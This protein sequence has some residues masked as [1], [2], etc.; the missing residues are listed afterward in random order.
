MHPSRL[1]GDLLLKWPRAAASW[2]EAA[3]VGNGRLGAVVF[4]G[5]HRAR[6]QINDSTVWSGTPGGPAA[7]LADV[8]AGGAGP[9]RLAGVRAAIRAGDHRRAESLLMTF[10]GRY[11]QEY[12]PY[13]DLYLTLDDARPAA[14]QGRTLNLDNG[15]V[16]ERIDLDGLPV[17]R[18]TWADATAG[19]LCTALA[20]DGGTTGL[21]LELTSPL[22]EVHRACDPDGITLGVEIPVDGA[23]SH[24]PDVPEPL[25]YA[26]EPVDGYDPFGAIALRVATDGTV[27]VRGDHLEIAGASRILVTLA[28]STSAA[29][30]WTGAPDAPADRD[31]HLRA[32]GEVAVRTNCSPPT[33]P[34]CAAWWTPPG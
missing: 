16:E 23:P 32:A 11:S 19:T 31:A 17:T 18:L 7:A 8:L 22:R 2:H 24:E 1:P 10:Q 25:R 13:A 27:T 4:G 20:A 30:F 9:E 21:R 26:D 3:P 12:L 28:T 34:T 15:V 14:Y 6:L 33:R 5:T 29:G